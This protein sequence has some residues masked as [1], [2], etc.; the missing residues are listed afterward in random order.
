[1]T[2]FQKSSLIFKR[3]E[4]NKYKLNIISMSEKMPIQEDLPVESEGLEKTLG[5][6]IA[7]GVEEGDRKWEAAQDKVELINKASLKLAEMNNPKNMELMGKSIKEGGT[8][9]MVGKE[10]M[11]IFNKGYDALKQLYTGEGMQ[12]GSEKILRQREATEALKLAEE[13]LSSK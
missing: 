13:V 8:F 11:D 12:E 4:L 1:L 3:S 2:F 6:T 10:E 9:E 5:E 7:K